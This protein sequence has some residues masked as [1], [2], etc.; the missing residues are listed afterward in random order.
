MIFKIH[1]RNLVNRFLMPIVGVALM[2][3]APTI[4]ARSTYIRTWTWSLSGL[5]FI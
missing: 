4:H 1:K 2:A 3:A 5:E